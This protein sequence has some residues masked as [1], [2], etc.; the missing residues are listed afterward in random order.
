MTTHPLAILNTSIA[1]VPGGYSLEP[2]SLVGARRV[3][4]AAPEILSAVGHQATAD[5]LTQL[6]GRLIPVN[7][8]AFQQQP[9]Q[10]ALVL[11]MRGRP[12]E[13]VVLDVAGM[14]ELGY[15]LLLLT[16]HARTRAEILAGLD[17]CQHGRHSRAGRGEP[18]ACYDCPSGQSAG[19]PHLHVVVGYDRGGRPVTL[20]DLLDQVGG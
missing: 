17:R 16:R 13:G 2:I 9:G 3:V 19:N 20:A 7:R 15:E 4:N 5:V 10:R 18:D 8:I 1:T 6:F 12:P 11:K 14:E